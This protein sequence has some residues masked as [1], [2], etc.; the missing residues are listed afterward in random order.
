MHAFITIICIKMSIK[1]T[2]LADGSYEVGDDSETPGNGCIGNCPSSVVI[3][4]YYGDA[5]VVSIAKYAFMERG[6]QSLTLPES[7]KF[8]KSF[9]FD[10]NSISNLVIPKYTEELG[11]Y[12][13]SA[14]TFRTVTIPQ[15]VRMIGCCPFGG[16]SNLQS[17][18][19]DPLNKYYCIDICGSL[20]TRN[21]TILI[22]ANPKMDPLSVPATVHTILKQALDQKS[23]FKH[24]II[25]G[26]VTYFEIGSFFNLPQLQTIHYYGKHV[27]PKNALVNIQNV[28]IYVCDDYDSSN[29]NSVSGTIQLGFCYRNSPKC[30]TS[31][32]NFEMNCYVFIYV[33]TLCCL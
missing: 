32:K 22:Q 12:C 11:D 29:G 2:K 9:A 15:Y 16:N 33:F 31:E 5:K 4:E 24:I 28:K 7:I 30:I 23:V 18:N 17:M 3:N 10:R 1:Y 21:Q 19:V 14:N 6:I 27:F 26:D 20:L 13:F 25:Y 8:I